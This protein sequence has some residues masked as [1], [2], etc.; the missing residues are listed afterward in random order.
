MNEN[1]DHD[2]ERRDL[3]K[4]V[5]ALSMAGLV[6]PVLAAT[7]RPIGV[8]VPG[9]GWVPVGDQSCAGDGTPLQFI[10]KTAPDPAPLTDEFKKY[11]QCPYCGMDRTEYNHSRH[12]VQYDDDLVDGTCSIHC[13]AVSLLLNLDRGPKAIYAADYGSTDDIKPLVRVDS[14]TYL[15]GSKLKGTMSA[16]SKLA[17]AQQAAAEAA[18]AAQGGKLAS[19]DEALTQSYTNMAKDTMMIRKNR[20]EK[21]R[22]MMEKK[23]T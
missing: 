19:F 4:L 20:A 13:L 7:D 6:G 9:K 14:A 21:M 23:A 12:L 2:Q 18:K 3:L 16:V 10:P 17:F 22:K 8:M 1:H 11:P 5:G 15:I